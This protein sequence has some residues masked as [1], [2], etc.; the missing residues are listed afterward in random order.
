MPRL[1]LPRREPQECGGELVALLDAAVGLGQRFRP[2]EQPD[3]L[4][5]PRTATTYLAVEQVRDSAPQVGV[6]VV[7]LQAIPSGPHAG[8]CLLGEVFG[9]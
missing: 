2:R 7:T 3:D 1:A 5:V 9:G 4:L 6:E 8:E